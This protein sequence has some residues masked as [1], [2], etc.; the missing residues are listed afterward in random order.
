LQQ[1]P[2]LIES[3]LY[4]LTLG[5]DAQN[6]IE[7]MEFY[8]LA[9]LDKIEKDLE[10]LLAENLLDK[11]FEDNA[12]MPIHQ[13]RK[14][15]GEADI[16]AVTVTGDLVIFELKRGA[17]GDEAMLQILRYA[18]GAGQWTYD[19][20]NGYYKKK[21]PQAELSAAHQ[22]A[23]ELSRELSPAEFNRNQHL[24]VVGSAANETL[25][26]SLAYWRSKG[27]SVEF[28]PYRIYKIANQLYFE[29]FAKPHDIHH[30]PKRIK[31]VILNTNRTYD[32][33]G[34]WHMLEHSRA[35]IWGEAQNYIHSLSKN[36]F[37]FL[38]HKHYDLVAAGQVTGKPRFD[39]DEAEAYVTVKWLNRIPVR[40]EG[41]REWMPFAKVTQLLEHGIYWART[42]KVPYL[43]PEESS[44]LLME[45]KKITDK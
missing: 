14:F 26:R 39:E 13:E 36:D 24:Y 11:L 15:Q 25:S 31:G 30:N 17:V 9:E 7:P 41:I 35:S 20:L 10:N 21:H 27:L 44:Y 28:I 40:A 6:A 42:L 43:S 12:L 2:T 29:F 1:G 16:Y 18:Q 33:D 34:I 32:E 23:F 8:E 22:G 37:V 38:S 5:E 3:I 4:K 45:L 19:T